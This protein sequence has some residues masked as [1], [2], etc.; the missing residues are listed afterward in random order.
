[1]SCLILFRMKEHLYT[2]KEMAGILAKAFPN[3]DPEQCARKIRHWTLMDLLKPYGKKYTGTG[4]S[5][6]YTEHEIRKASILM[7]L[8]NWKVPLPLL[9]DNFEI[10]IDSYEDSEEWRLAV[11]GEANVFLA[12]SRTDDIVS[13]QMNAK[14][15]KLSFLGKGIADFKKTFVDLGSKSDQ[16]NSTIQIELPSSAILI[17]VSRIFYRLEIE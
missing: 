11:D 7:E 4:K 3:E 1:M 14:E 17:N 10:M 12:L 15:P 13:W 16:E 5:R 2:L 9:E 6:L 8:T